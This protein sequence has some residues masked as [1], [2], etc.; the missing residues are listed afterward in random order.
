MLNVMKGNENQ[1]KILILFYIY[2]YINA[3]LRLLRNLFS[4]ILSMLNVGLQSI[5]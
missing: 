1:A 3:S 4:F 2:K 5:A